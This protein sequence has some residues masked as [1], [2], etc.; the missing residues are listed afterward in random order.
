M[1]VV[2][3]EYIER[4]IKS[5]AR[6]NVNSCA[7]KPIITSEQDLLGRVDFSRHLAQAICENDGS[8]GLVIGMYGK[9]GTGKTSIIN[10]MFEYIDNLYLEN[11]VRNKPILIKFSPWNYSDK[12]D[13]INMYFKV[14][15]NEI[16]K[17]GEGKFRKIIGR[18]LREYV[19]AIDELNAD[20][21]TKSSNS[22]ILKALATIGA[23]FLMQEPD[24]E[25]TKRRLEEKLTESKQ[26]ILVVIDD[27]DRLTNEQIR[28]VF[29]L[30]KQVADFP[31]VTYILVMD[32]DIVASALN[33]IHNID[34]NEYLEKIVQVPF[35]IPV[36]QKSQV[37]IMLLNELIKIAKEIGNDDG[38]YNRF[39]GYF[40]RVSRDCIEP[41]IKT[42][43]DI[44]RVVNTFRFRYSYLKDETCF[45]DLAA[46]TTIEVM[47]PEL[48][49][50]IS[51]NRDFLCGGS[52]RDAFLSEAGYNQFT[53]LCDDDSLQQKFREKYQREFDKLGLNSEIAMRC[54]ATMFPIVARDIGLDKNSEISDIELMADKRAA[55][56][57]R[58][59]IYFSFDLSKVKLSSELI[60][61]CINYLDFEE[62]NMEINKIPEDDIEDFLAEII[63]FIH[64]IPNWR[65]GTVTKFLMKLI[66]D[67]CDIIGEST[68]WVIRTNIEYSIVERIKASINDET[69]YELFCTA[70]DNLSEKELVRIV[71][72][73]KECKIEVENQHSNKPQL[74][75]REFCDKILE[76]YEDKIRW[77]LF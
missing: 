4:M 40:G 10:M 18:A 12:N 71:T 51:N 26:R 20:N 14:L 21:K 34:G 70:L 13:L 59:Q 67:K 16:Y 33:E 36:L 61:G 3:F 68:P 39:M 9:W 75:N 53:D 76:K 50:W 47:E 74:L 65:I 55:Y 2:V 19:K 49:K 31:N 41:Y 38:S 73:L 57:R 17:K 25:E 60:V 22:I 32:R 69:R 77:I 27:I 1:Q 46:I 6:W 5:N 48:Y 37:F 28:D 66:Q 8:D 29:Q 56:D 52:L 44:N 23:D 35:V 30:V 62:L 24:L 63:R 72:M 54:V 58:F 45:E 11:S 43:R 42:P 64:Y 15:K 7:D